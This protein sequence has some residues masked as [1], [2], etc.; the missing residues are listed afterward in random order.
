MNPRLNF[1]TTRL[2]LLRAAALA[3]ACPASAATLTWDNGNTANGTTI[4]PATGTWDTTAGN[5]FWN[6]AG[7]NAAWTQTNATTA[8]NA[9]IFGGADGSYA[10]SLGAALAAQSLKFQNSGY[11][12][13]AAAVRVLRLSNSVSAASV[14]GA[15]SGKT[16][17]IG[18]NVTVQQAG[19]AFFGS[20]GVTAGG[21][22]IIESGGVYEQ[23]ASNTWAMDG[24]GSIIRVKTGGILRM[25]GASSQLVIGA[26]TGSN[27]ILHVDGG[28][29]SLS[30]VNTNF[31]ISSGTGAVNGS[32]TLDSGSVSMPAATTK[33]FTLGSQSGNI[34]TANLNGGTLAVRQIVKGVADAVATLNLNGGSIRAVSAASGAAFLDGLNTANVRNGGAIFDTNGFDITVNQTLSHSAIGGDNA[35]DGGVTKNGAGR[36]NL[37]GANTYT[38]PTTVNAGTLAPLSG[39]AFSSGSVVVAGGSLLLDTADLSGIA[40]VDVQ[41]AGTMAIVGDRS[42]SGTLS[43]TGT[44]DLRDTFQNTLSV[45][46]PLSLNGAA[47]NLELL[48]SGSDRIA[49]AGALSGTATINLTLAAGETLTSGSYTLLTA[50]GGISPANFTLG[51]RPTGFNTYSFASSTPTALILT[52]GVGGTKPPTAYWTGRASGTGSPADPSNNWGYGAGLAPTKSNWATNAAGST[53][54]LQVPGENTDVIFTAA[55]ATGNAGLLAT[56]TEGAYQIKS[57]LFD[58]PAATGITT[59]QID[60]HGFPL[61]I[62]GAGI[63]LATSSNAAATINGTGSV[64]LPE[65]DTTFRNNNTRLLT[66]SPPLSATQSLSILTLEGTGNG[67]MTLGPISNGTGSLDLVISHPGLTTLQGNQSFTGPTTLDEG[68]LVIDNAATFTSPITLNVAAADALTLAQTSQNLVLPQAITGSGGIV[69][70]GAGSLTLGNGNNGY[71]AGTAVNGGTVLLNSSAGAGTAAGQ[72]CTVGQ[73]TPTNVFTVNNGATVAINGT[74]PFGNSNMV[75]EFTPS[76]LINAG[77]TLTGNAF[78]AFLPNLTLNGGSIQVG[79][80]NTTGGYNTNL[81]LIGTVIV[82]GSTPVSVTTTGTG[83]NATISLGGNAATSTVTFQVADVTGDA[84]TDFTIGSV[85]R[86]VLANSSTLVKTGPGTMQLTATN[87]YTGSTTVE[88]GEL[89]LGTASLANASAVSIGATATLNLT[90]GAAD[91]IGTLTLGGVQMAAGTYVAQGSAAP[92]IQTPRLKGSGSLVVTTGPGLTYDSWASVIPNP[93]DRDRT[94]DP[95]HDGFTNLHEFLFGGS[96]VTANG[97][98]TQATRSGNDLILRWLQLTGSGTYALKESASLLDNPWPTSAVVPTNDADQSN[99]PTGYTRRMATIPVNSARK[100]VRVEGAE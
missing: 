42:T 78:V 8:T 7:T 29:V 72:N 76:V 46:G 5:L 94:D 92:G 90:H 19:T 67:G 53:D 75:P 22:L 47:L 69:K 93:D 61:T 1:I 36:L 65:A 18:A 15:D 50:P 34:G 99:V 86:N 85:I 79:N 20:T 87:T 81:G 89:I 80:G 57:L 44:I 23:T 6:N 96:P 77:G 28:T 41:A 43:A 100:F 27:P 63:T 95:D 49:V 60:T 51:T 12:L 39:S 56:Q 13:S 70:N 38:G 21:T 10:V 58:L 62:G 83:G 3:L 4:D 25:T 37:G 45:N 33:P 30:G 82:S 17:T 14:L 9:A 11:T 71:A 97:S 16:A 74:A 68:K 35:V 55:N 32:L 26:T 73:M 64:A 66:V 88:A 84:S 40:G 54:A 24:T 48:T 31:L 98:L 59:T 2:S 52:V 91:T